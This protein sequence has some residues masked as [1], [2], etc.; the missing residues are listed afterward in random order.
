VD[1]SSVSDYRLALR[2]LSN[3]DPYL[4]EHSALPGP[5]G[6]IEL[7]LAAAE[8]ASPER[9]LAWL[10]WDSVRAPTS[11]PEEFLVFCGVLGLG[12]LAADG[13]DLA[14]ERLQDHASDERWRVR[15]AVAMAVQRIADDDFDKALAVV[16]WWARGGWM[17]Q[18][19][20]VA[21]LCEPRLLTTHER[22]TAVLDLL[23]VVTNAL[24]TAAGEDRRSADYRTLRQGLG[25]CWREAV[26]ADLKTGRIRMERWIGSADDDV[27]WVMRNNLSKK[28]LQ[29]MDDAW[30][31]AQRERLTIT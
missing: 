31:V 1:V 6:N 28:R 19:A 27:R 21:A 11:T 13:D 10:A 12:R 25:Y 9:I 18:R 20:A 14:L 22:T 26:A 3:W 23:D 29:R 30:V 7:G 15:E 4:L 17:V 2:G 16:E 8:E 24:A 5:R